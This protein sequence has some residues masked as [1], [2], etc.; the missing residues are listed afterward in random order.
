MTSY[1]DAVDLSYTVPLG[2]RR[3]VHLRSVCHLSWR[4]SR[5]LLCSLLPSSCRKIW[6][7][8]TYIIRAWQCETAGMSSTGSGHML[9]RTFLP[10]PSPSADLHC[11]LENKLGCRRETGRCFVTVNISISHWMSLKVVENGT[12]RKLGYGW[13]SLVTMVL[14]CIISEIKR[15]IGQKSLFLCFY[16]EQ[17]SHFFRQNERP[18]SVEVQSDITVDCNSWSR[19]AHIYC[20]RYRL[21]TNTANWN[22]F[23]F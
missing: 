19:S 16:A 10:P 7:R 5:L 17:I 8:T 4:D 6:N 12:I 15:D 3:V 14:Y 20:G 2:G 13:Q 11:E 23:V 18:V 21:T 22:V 9:P 1:T